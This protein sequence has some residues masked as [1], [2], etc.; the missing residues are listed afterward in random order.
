VNSAK[1]WKRTGTAHINPQRPCLARADFK[2][3]SNKAYPQLF[4]WA[5]Q[6]SVKKGSGYHKGFFWTVQM[7]VDSLYKG[8]YRKK[9]TRQYRMEF[10]VLNV[11]LLFLGFNRKSVSHEKPYLAD[12]YLESQGFFMVKCPRCDSEFDGATNKWQQP[13]VYAVEVFECPKCGAKFRNDAER[14]KT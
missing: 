6:F 8:G 3:S 2:N 1:L 5:I 4:S 12:A 11:R 9:I 10:Y 13:S 7:L 14:A